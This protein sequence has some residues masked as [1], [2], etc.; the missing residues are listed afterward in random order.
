M[1]KLTLVIIL[2]YNKIIINFQILEFLKNFIIK[3]NK[4][5]SIDSSMKQKLSGELIFQKLYYKSFP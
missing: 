1:A 5:A 4:T 3:I 2:V